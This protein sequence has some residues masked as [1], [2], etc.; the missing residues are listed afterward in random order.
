M[1]HGPG[2]ASSAQTYNFTGLDKK[3]GSVTTKPS[4]RRKRK[5]DWRPANRL[6]NSHGKS[7]PSSGRLR[8]VK[9]PKRPVFDTSSDCV[10]N[11]WTASF[12]GDRA[13]FQSISVMCEQRLRKACVMTEH[14]PMPDEFRTMAACEALGTMLPVFERYGSL[15]TL[16]I[17]ELL[18]SVYED[19]DL[20]INQFLAWLHPDPGGQSARAPA[21]VMLLK[22]K[23]HFVRCREL[24][25]EVISLQGALEEKKKHEGTLL[26]NLTS[27]RN[28]MRSVLGKD[29]LLITRFIF[30]SWRKVVE[31]S[32]MLRKRF[33]RIRLR[34]WFNG[35][36][37]RLTRRINQEAKYQLGLR[38]REL[39]L[40]ASDKK[41][42]AI[43]TQEPVG[44]S[45]QITRAATTR[46]LIVAS[47]LEQAKALMAEVQENG[48]GS[49]RENGLVMASVTKMAAAARLAEER[50]RLDIGDDIS[51]EDE[52]VGTG[53]STTGTQ[54]DP[55]FDSRSSG[56]ASGGDPETS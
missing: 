11:R 31:N 27:A 51:V 38:E 15:V 16:V 26:S 48:N 17:K 39:M 49:I 30:S 32:S 50:I 54:T 18:R 20:V 22:S 7:I 19:S 9:P 1:H 23:P 45:P 43:N 34:I 24:Q 36:R 8:V 33:K 28:S 42:G 12:D 21:E 47:L 2:N 53:H 40:Y 52:D 46:E 56:R 25:K 37:T 55:V 35:L 4:V 41:K 10:M 13:R 14:A 3:Q 44:E 6:P 29:S 5:H